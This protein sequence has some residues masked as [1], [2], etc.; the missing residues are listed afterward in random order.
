M[1]GH[2]YSRS[3]LIPIS[4]A[5]PLH[6]DLKRID[7]EVT[8]AGQLFTRSFECKPNQNC[9][10]TWDGKDAYGRP[11]QG[12]T[13]VKVRI[14]YVYPAIY[15]NPAPLDASFGQFGR[16][17]EGWSSDTVRLEAIVWQEWQG[18]VSNWQSQ[19]LGLGG[20]TF[21][22]HH[23]Y[24]PFKQVLMQGDGNQELQV[25]QALLL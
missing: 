18:D 8:V 4:T 23:V 20:W 12:T 9:L 15:Q 3:L 7:L 6:P 16:T 11:V 25:P 21:D 5:E 14:G 17:P 1:E 13:A 10:F 19:L 22:V 24:D 2:K